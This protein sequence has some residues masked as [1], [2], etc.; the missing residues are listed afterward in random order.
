MKDTPRTRCYKELEAFANQNSKHLH[1]SLDDIKPKTSVWIVG[2]KQ[3]R[4]DTLGEIKWDT[5]WRKYCM[6]FYN[7]ISV[8]ERYASKWSPS[9]FQDALNFIKCLTI[10]HEVMR[11]GGT[12]D[13]EKILTE[14]FG[15]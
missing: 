12:P 7:S 10:K 14:V 8:R 4:S 6:L 11:G 3:D 5:G 13:I 1:F 2:N 9:C 15:E